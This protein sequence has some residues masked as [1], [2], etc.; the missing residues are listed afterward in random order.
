MTLLFL[1][2]FALAEAGELAE[3]FGGLRDRGR[4]SCDVE[5]VELVGKRVICLH[6]WRQCGGRVET[7]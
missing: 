7:P 2:G 6:C 4:R 1:L 3:D 5:L